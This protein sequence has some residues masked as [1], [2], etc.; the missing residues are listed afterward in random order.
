MKKEVKEIEI[1]VKMPMYDAKEMSVKDDYRSYHDFVQ[2]NIE[3]IQFP[4]LENVSVILNEEGKLFSMEPNVY[5]PEYEDLFVGPIMFVGTS[6][7]RMRS[8]TEKEKNT[9]M[10]YANENDIRRVAEKFIRE[11]ATEREM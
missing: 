6:G 1:V 10:Q 3:M 4:G 7:E 9:V 5:S 2:G 8:L 11:K